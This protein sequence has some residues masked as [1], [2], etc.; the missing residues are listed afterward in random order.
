MN[1]REL[2]AKMAELMGWTPIEFE[3]DYHRWCPSTDIADAWL[4]VEK[5]KIRFSLT[6][7]KTFKNG[8]WLCRTGDRM[9]VITVIA[10]TAPLAICRAALMAV[11]AEGMKNG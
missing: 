6:S 7:L 4:V 3:S 8:K 11:E 1:N 10:D 5:I 9:N 2:D